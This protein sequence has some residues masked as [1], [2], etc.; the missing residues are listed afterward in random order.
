M[1]SMKNSKIITTH[2][3]M[4]SVDSSHI[5]D[6]IMMSKGKMNQKISYDRSKKYLH[7]VGSKSEIYPRKYSILYGV[8]SQKLK[9]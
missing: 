5:I 4:K 3:E 6:T 1:L 8:K 7:Q 9:K 2:D